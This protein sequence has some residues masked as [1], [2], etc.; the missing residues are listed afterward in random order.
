MTPA[1]FVIPQKGSI[2]AIIKKLFR[3][4]LFMVHGGLL[5]LQLFNVQ[6][7]K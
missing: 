3:C 2:E 6:Q 7:T 4:S 5:E 1:N